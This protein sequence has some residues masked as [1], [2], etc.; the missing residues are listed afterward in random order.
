MWCHLSDIFD[1]NL[2]ADF[3]SVASG[4]L[5][6]IRMMSLTPVVVHLEIKL[7]NDLFLRKKWR[8]EKDL[9]L[10][11]IK[12]LKNRQAL[13][14]AANLQELDLVVESLTT[15]L[16]QPLCLTWD[17]QTTTTSSSSQMTVNSDS[18]A[19]T[20]Q[21]AWGDVVSQEAT[22]ASSDLIHW[23]G[24]LGRCRLTRGNGSII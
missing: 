17:W 23:G 9:L 15:R 4:G 24:G 5:L 2:G 20:G 22:G 6:T 13:C 1:K 11:L 18:A 10:K 14:K 7:R 3:E 21:M 12:T 8:S 19:L 16:R